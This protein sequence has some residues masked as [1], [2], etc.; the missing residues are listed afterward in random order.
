MHAVTKAVDSRQGA[1][2]HCPKGHVL[3]T[4]TTDAEA[5]V[6][7]MCS[8][9]S[10]EPGR[11][12]F[13]GCALCQFDLCPS[14]LDAQIS[15]REVGSSPSLRA[16]VRL[17]DLDLGL[18][19]VRLEPGRVSGIVFGRV[20]KDSANRYSQVPDEL[21]FTVRVD[22]VCV[23]VSDET[24][25]I[26][27]TAKELVVSLSCKSRFSSSQL[28]RHLGVSPGRFNSESAQ[29]VAGSA[30][31]AK[32]CEG[33]VAKRSTAKCVGKG[34]KGRSVAESRQV[35]PGDWQAELL[36]RVHQTKVRVDADLT[37]QKQRQRVKNSLGVA[38]CTG[39]VLLAVLSGF[40]EYPCLGTRSQAA[41]EF[42]W[43]SFAQLGERIKV[44]AARVQSHLAPD[45]R[46]GICGANSIDWVVVD[47]ACILVGVTVIPLHPLLGS[48]VIDAIIEETGMVL[49]FHDAQFTTHAWVERLRWAVPIDPLVLDMLSCGEAVPSLPALRA[50][51]STVSILY[52]SG[53]TGRPKGALVPDRAW[54]G[55]FSRATES[56]DAGSVF[57]VD[58]SFALSSPR[59]TAFEVLC[60]G[61]RVG[62]VRPGLG[63][64]LEGD[65]RCL[66]PTALVDPPT[67]LEALRKH[68]QDEAGTEQ[69]QL[70][71][72]R[73][74]SGGSLRRL[75]TGGA[76]PGPSLL[77]WLRRVFGP[78]L[79]HNSYGAC[80][81]GTIAEDGRVL[82][83]VQIKLEDWGGYS[84]ADVPHARGQLA[85]FINSPSQH[86]GFISRDLQRKKRVR[87]GRRRREELRGVS[88][89]RTL[90]RPVRLSS[91]PFALKAGD[92]RASTPSGSV[93]DMHV[94]TE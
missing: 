85:V 60:S 13:A 52:T 68:F 93:C 59:T 48:E 64:W 40:A 73:A 32:G 55:L 77:A 82:P 74:L 26:S 92:R 36:V 56:Q 81:V 30:K 83:G 47:W 17:K 10:Q 28:A 42:D 67:V 39:Q 31:G 41:S 65:L 14:C 66:R 91:D 23:D 63:K 84:S 9:R 75:T 44:V 50:P 27:L 57:P 8:V 70:S 4:L 94:V 86:A 89:S 7:D 87:E 18:V 61:G 69:Q 90:Q 29:G 33:K 16:S 53:T 80:E 21:V 11:W 62:L 3:I 72:C 43:I 58:A 38:T 25:V 24:G 78:E 54:C 79:V 35:V 12:G 45:S 71:E 20:L 37:F 22:G 76:L 2:S 46:A 51:E 15:L 49:G 88:L 1:T 34:P 5:R 6:C 19:T